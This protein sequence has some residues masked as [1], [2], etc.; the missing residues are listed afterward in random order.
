MAAAAPEDAAPPIAPSIVRDPGPAAA[1]VAVGD[2]P[3]DGDDSSGAPAADDETLHAAALRTATVALQDAVKALD[4][5][6]GATRGTAA[7]LAV[8]RD[9]L[10]AEGDDGGTPTSEPFAASTA[11]A[12]PSG[13]VDADGAPAGASSDAGD[14]DD[15]SD[16]EVDLTEIVERLRFELRAWQGI[17]QSRKA[18]VAAAEAEVHRCRSRLEAA[19]AANNE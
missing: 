9:E 4:E 8:A 10:L 5:A 1:A 12:G 16:E 13:A 14:D 3:R 6:V 19:R 18:T 7:A 2:S 15:D 17:V 11:E